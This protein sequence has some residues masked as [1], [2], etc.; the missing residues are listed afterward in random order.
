MLIGKKKQIV[1][2]TAFKGVRRHESFRRQVQC[3]DATL[4][5]RGRGMDWISPPT[6]AWRSDLP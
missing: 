3:P 4:N 2:L 5:Q 1:G 6:Q